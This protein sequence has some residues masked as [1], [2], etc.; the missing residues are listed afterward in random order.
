[1]NQNTTERLYSLADAARFLDIH[2]NTAR[3]WVKS[4]KLKAVQPG[5][6]YKVPGAEIK[7]LGGIIPSGKQEVAS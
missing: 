6:D 1:M 5:R 3:A 2:Q 7:R 4:G